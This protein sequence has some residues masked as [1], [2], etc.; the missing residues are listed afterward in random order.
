L[1]AENRVSES[2]REEGHD[3]PARVLEKPALLAEVASIGGSSRQLRHV[4]RDQRGR[5][6]LIG[7]EGLKLSVDDDIEQ[8][9]SMTAAMAFRTDGCPA[10]EQVLFG[11]GVKDVHRA[12]DPARVAPDPLLLSADVIAVDGL[13]R[14]RNPV[15][16]L[17]ER[18]VEMHVHNSL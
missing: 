11:G 13:Q 6:E 7:L 18:R 1:R 9:G 12:H 16:A 10:E 5:L 4:A 2:K 8:L 15:E 14:L 17:A 3:V